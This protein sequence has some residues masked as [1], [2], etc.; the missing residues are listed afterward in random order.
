MT[1]NSRSSLS[2]HELCL[3]KAERAT[4]AVQ[5]S[6][7][8]RLRRVAGFAWGPGRGIRAGLTPIFYRPY[9]KPRTRIIPSKRP[10][11]SSR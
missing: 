8:N 5:L 6:R 3:L 11:R 4:T 10:S 1:C 2:D 9:V 7:V